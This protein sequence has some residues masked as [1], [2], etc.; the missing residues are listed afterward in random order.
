MLKSTI[1]RSVSMMLAL[2]MLTLPTACAENT[3]AEPAPVVQIEVFSASTASTTAA[4][5]YDNTWWGK[6][7]KE[8]IGVSL[9]VLPTGDQAAQKLQALMASGSLPDIVVFNST[10][11]LQNAIRGNMLV[12]LDEHLDAL[13]NVALNAAETLQF[14]R[15][16]VSNGT[17]NAYGVPT[18]GIGP[19]DLGAEPNWG[20]YLRWDLFKQI[21]EP[22]IATY[23]DYLTVLADMQAL[24]PTTEDGKKAYGLT[25]WKDWD[26]YSMFMATEVG[27]TLGIDCGDQLGQLPFL[28]VDFNTG[29][30][31]NTLDADSTY[32]QALKF[33]FKANQM[34]LLDPDSL[35]QTYDTA[36]SKITEGRV[37]FSWWS[38]FND[39]YNTIDH[40]DAEPPTGFTAVL[41]ENTK[42]L[43]ASKITIGK[44]WPIAISSATKN[45][46]ACLK[47]VDF[48]FSTEGLQLL[49]NGPEGV[50][51]ELG[52]NGKPQLTTEGWK[53]INDMT[54][55][56]PEGGTLGDGVRLLGMNPLSSATINPK[57]NDA[58]HY[59]AWESTK[60][61]KIDHQTK[62]QKDW[63]SVTGY[64][65][66][67]DYVVSKGMT[68]E[69]PIAQSMITPMTDEI[70]ALAARIGD[71]VKTS[72][73]QMIF[74]KDEAEFQS[75][76]DDMLTKAEGLGLAD[77]YASSLQGWNAA[78]DLVKKYE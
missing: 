69:I 70:S 51:W 24:Q 30:T 43:I 26:N 6:I 71:I 52:S 19:T 35:T 9:N 46:D 7:L 17:G 48:M 47:Y 29:E 63:A 23:E 45:L 16:N 62:L 13:P 4:G 5:V 31:L 40:V 75:L 74:A 3:K 54:L 55:E 18:S 37:F 38:W 21:G 20:P 28:Q 12:N 39:A 41:P 14:Y 27:P 1:S 42:T 66:T 73:W 50:T 78:L 33:Y 2:A 59:Q 72:S 22:K 65:S 15:D 25:L 10:K 64:S 60:Q 76:Y 57:T 58:I 8:K 32:I 56:L 49:Y 53:Y 44:Q 36:K 68:T 67:I 11:D 34:G 77:V 61:Y